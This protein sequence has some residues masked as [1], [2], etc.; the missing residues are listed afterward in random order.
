MKNLPMTAAALLLLAGLSA[1]APAGEPKDEKE[2]EKGL[3]AG[4][5]DP[6]FLLRV[7]NAVQKGLQWVLAQQAADGS[8]PNPGS[9]AEGYPG[10]PTALALLAVLKSGLARQHEAVEKGFQHLRAQPLQKTYTVAFTIMALEA[11][12]TDQDVEKRI[13]GATKPVAG[14]KPKIPPVD[15]DWM[16]ELV[17]FL[18]QNV[19]Y[20]N[21]VRDGATGQV[22][23]PKDCWRYPGPAEVG[24]HSNT[25]YAILGLRSARKCGIDSPPDL[26]A[27]ILEHFLENQEKDG[28]KVARVRMLED[29]KHGYVSYKTLTDVPDTARGWCYSTA[30]APAATGGD[31]SS[32]TTGS[33]TTIGVSS[34]IIAAECLAG[35]PKLGNKLPAVQKAVND[36][37]AW[38]AHKF[39]VETNPGHPGGQ[40]L[41]YYLYGLERAGVLAGV[42]NFGTHDWY[43]EGAEWLMK[44]QAADGAWTVK[45]AEGHLGATAFALLF[46]TKATTPGLVK[47]TR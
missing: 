22:I 11:R 32:A 43:R 44:N 37:L 19:T 41:Y 29:S 47:V 9:G 20:S 33:M 36:G 28:P 27:L 39:T 10:G 31:E 21:D 12:W 1:P 30:H 4:D 2:T 13:Q 38:I 25:Q 23:G 18:L 16:R 24:D 26:W 7:S 6:E 8:F 3:K 5:R 15:L 34:L 35:N 40:W 42:K 14:P 46:L 45:A 17:E